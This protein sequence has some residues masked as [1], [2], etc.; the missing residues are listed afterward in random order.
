[1]ERALRKQTKL[2]I[3]SDRIAGAAGLSISTA[4]RLLD[5]KDNAALEDRF[6][7]SE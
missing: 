1:M 4:S 6:P 5:K 3:I 7:F 2:T